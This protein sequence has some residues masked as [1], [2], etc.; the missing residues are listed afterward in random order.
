MTL[1]TLLLFDEDRASE[2][3]CTIDIAATTVTVGL[4]P[5]AVLTATGWEVKPYGLCRGDVCN[6]ARFGQ[7]VALDELAAALQ[8]PLAFEV[9]GDRVVGM[10]GAASGSTLQAGDVAPQLSLPDVDGNPVAVTGVGRKTA[11][12]TWSTWCGCRYELPAWL[13][14]A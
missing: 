11:V 12:V 13:E 2:V 3:A 14:L 1:G 7:S 4:T 5:D 10:L 8:R 9:L 6:R